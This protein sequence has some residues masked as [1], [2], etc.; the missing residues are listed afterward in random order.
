MA[1]HP[2]SAEPVA[3]AILAKAPVPGL[4]KTRLEPVLGTDGA[5]ALQ[6]RLIKRTIETARAAGVGPITVWATP[7]IRYPIFQDLSGLPD[8]AVARQPDS[9]LGGRMLYAVMAASPALVIGTDCPALE[10]SHLR[11]AADVLR[12]GFDAVV[13]SAEDG[14]Y[15]LIGMRE[16]HMALFSNIRWGSD[17]VMADTRRRMLELGLSWREPLQLWDLD[18]PEDL[19]RLQQEGLGALLHGLSDI[20]ADAGSE[21]L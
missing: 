12:S 19:D 14:G 1:M 4:V 8:V 7:D 17:T 9:D 18:R 10:A 13:I 20:G 3:V 21:A 15:A 2:V 6:A 11:S 16:P 5:A